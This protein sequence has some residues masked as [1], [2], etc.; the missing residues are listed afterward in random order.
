MAEG[1]PEILTK[2]AEIEAKID[3]DRVIYTKCA[4]CNADGIVGGDP[5]SCTACGG[6]GFRTHGKIGKT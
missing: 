4:S 2:L 6:S 1:I 5:S 3:A